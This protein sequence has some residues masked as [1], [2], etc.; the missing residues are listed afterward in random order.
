MPI[1]N[2]PQAFERKLRN[3][4]I[5]QEVERIKKLEDKGRKPIEYAGDTKPLKG[6]DW[7]NRK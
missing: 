1:N 3:R 6:F 7:W 5:K 2:G 4:L